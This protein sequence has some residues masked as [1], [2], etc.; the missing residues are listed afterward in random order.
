MLR[1]LTPTALPFTLRLPKELNPPGKLSVWGVTP[2][3]GHVP[4]SA[5]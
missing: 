1:L 4:I 5:T 2:D 3:P